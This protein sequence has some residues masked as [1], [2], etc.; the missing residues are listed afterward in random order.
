[1][2]G[3]QTT[4]GPLSAAQALKE[5]LALAQTSRTDNYH[6]WLHGLPSEPRIWEFAPDHLRD[7]EAIVAAL[8]KPP[9]PGVARIHSLLTPGTQQLLEL[10]RTRPGRPVPP[11]L[12]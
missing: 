7:A 3:T 4:D 5:E 9:R 10:C 11:R 2:A 6:Q 12:L 1:M 8:R